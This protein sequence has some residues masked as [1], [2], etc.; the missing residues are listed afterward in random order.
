MSSGSYVGVIAVDLAVTV[1][2]PNMASAFAD[3]VKDSCII[4]ACFGLYTLRVTSGIQP[5]MRLVAATR[6]RLRTEATLW[7]AKNPK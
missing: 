6:H 7:K 4:F 2:T 3:A 1:P 5:P